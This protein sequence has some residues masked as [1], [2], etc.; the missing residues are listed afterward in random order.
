MSAWTKGQ[1]SVYFVSA[2]T[3]KKGTAEVHADMLG[4]LAVHDALSV[5]TVDKKPVISI[6]HVATGLKVS[7]T[8]FDDRSAAFN[9]VKALVALPVIWDQQQP[10]TKENRPFLRAAV[11]AICALCGGFEVESAMD[12]PG[13]HA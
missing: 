1:L 4:G 8:Y 5:E 6:T 12:Q 3:G 7:P 2:A 10:V 13:G 11:E 9:A